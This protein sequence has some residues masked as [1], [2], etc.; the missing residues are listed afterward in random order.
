MEKKIEILEN[1]KR[2]ITST[3]RSII[4]DQHVEVIFGNEVKKIK[5]L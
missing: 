5:K 3:V 4:G 1:F 2:A